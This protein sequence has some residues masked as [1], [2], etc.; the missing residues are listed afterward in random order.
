MVCF[1][2]ALPFCVVLDAGV[3]PVAF[4]VLSIL[5]SVQT[6]TGCVFSCVD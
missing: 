4:N 2:L 6:L 5:L 3:N 1:L